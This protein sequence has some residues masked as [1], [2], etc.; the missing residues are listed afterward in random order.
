[1]R[2]KLIALA[3]ST[4]FAVSSF[5]AVQWTMVPKQSQLTF[6]GTQAGA[7]FEG[8]FEKFT[9]D[10]KFDPK[11]L[12]TS[13]FD[14]K[15]DMAS[16]NSQDGERDTT[17]KDADLFAVKQFPSA[18]YVAE[19]FTDKGKGQYAAS[20]KLTLRNV[21]KDVPIEFTF[22]QKDAGALLKG[23]ASIKRLD[24]GVGQGD[25]KDTSTVANEVKVKFT[26]SLAKG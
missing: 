8:K 13:H 21:T 25:W 18:H 7:P 22:E 11:D 24:F 1:M 6:V 14:V 26:L 10:I 20:G 4:L 9:A 3:S 16:V 19:K 2:A 15:I 5:A 12:A 23:S 17:L